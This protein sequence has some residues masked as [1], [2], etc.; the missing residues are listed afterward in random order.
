MGVAGA[1]VSNAVKAM[2][3]EKDIPYFPNHQVTTVDSAHKHLSFA[4]GKSTTFDILAYVPPHRA[5]HVMKTSGLIGENGWVSVDKYTLQTCHEGVFAIGDVVA[6]PLTLGKPLPKAGVF[7]HGQAEVVARN[8]AALVDGKEPSAR[9]KGH[10]ECFIEVGN[11]KAGFGG[12]DFYA[13]PAPRV[14]LHAP[15]RRWHMGKVLFE[16]AWLYGKFT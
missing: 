15:S 5:P 4:N 8:I 6:I 7:A 16:K 11:G 13:E 14:T 2:L 1:E 9:Y 3:A 12:G 10:G